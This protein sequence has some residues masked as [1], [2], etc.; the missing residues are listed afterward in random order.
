MRRVLALVAVLA[1]APA[2]CGG[3]DGGGSGE[4]ATALLKR[5]FATDVDSGVLTFDARLEVRGAPEFRDPLELR[6]H[7]PFRAAPTPTEMPDLDVDF[8]ASGAGQTFSGSL[9]TTREN[10]WVEYQGETYEVGETLWTRFLEALR[11]QNEDQA[12]TFG[13]AGVDPLDWIDDP[14][15]DGDEEIGGTATTKVTG[16]LDMEALLLDVNRLS[17]AQR[18]PES[19]MREVADAF[20]EVDF[21][22][23]IGKDDIWRRV[24]AHTE[25]EVP[26]DERGA[27]GGASGGDLSIDVRVDEPNQPVHIEGPSEARSIAELLE[28]LGIPP[29]ALLGPGAASGGV[30]PG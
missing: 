20:P 9:I 30:V 14:E 7:G 26:E 15:V 19:D 16:A 1:L 18:L 29:E 8:T 28:G 6:F 10:A 11:R 4:D 27:F 5:G 24:S 2:G 23:W 3:D 22:A 12:Q 17:T 13:E 21:E 25:F